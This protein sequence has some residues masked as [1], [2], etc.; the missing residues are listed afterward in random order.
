M[1]KFVAAAGIVLF[2]VFGL[3]PVFSQ[4][5]PLLGAW[6]YDPHAPENVAYYGVPLQTKLEY[7]GAYLAL[8]ALLAVMT[9][10]VH[11]MLGSMM[12]PR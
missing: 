2:V 7:G 3:Q 9:Y 5:A 8:A 4:G 11:E 1:R 12:R 6:R 10:D